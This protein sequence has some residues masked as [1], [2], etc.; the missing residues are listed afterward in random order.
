MTVLSI[1]AP[2]RASATICEARVSAAISSLMPLPL[3]AMVAKVVKL[4]DV[5]NLL[6]TP[7]MM[8]KDVVDVVKK[9]GCVATPAI[10]TRPIKRR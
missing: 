7:R 9:D 1:D 10:Q 5:T 3:S 8:S 6:K 4:L 2:I